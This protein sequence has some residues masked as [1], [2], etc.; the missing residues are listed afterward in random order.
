MNHNE[1]PFFQDIIIGAGI[2]GLSYA[3]FSPE[4]NYMI[5]EKES[6]I[7]GYCRTVK[8][9]GYV[10][11]YSGH[12]FHFRDADIEKLLRKGIR[13]DTIVT[14]YKSTQIRYLDRYIDF[15]F[16]QNIHQ[17][18]K[19]EFIDCL[20]DFYFKDETP[21]STFKEMVYGKLGKSI[22]EKFL[23]PYNEKLYA[24]DLNTLDHR[25]M[26]RFFPD[27]TLKSIIGNF[28]VAK[29]DSYNATFTCSSGGA[30]EYV[31]SLFKQVPDEKVR[32]NESVISIEPAQKIVKTNKGTYRYNRLISSMPFPELLDKCGL[33]YD[34]SIYTWNQ[35][36]VFNLGFDKKGNDIRNHWIYF[37]ESKYAF[38]RVGYYDNILNQNRMSLY[39]E[40]GYPKDV[41]IDVDAIFSQVMQDLKIAGIITGHQLIDHHSVIMNPAYVHV[42][43]QSLEDIPLKMKELEEYNIYSIG[44]YGGWK[45]C[46]I[47]DNIKEARSLVHQ[48]QKTNLS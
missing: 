15:P 39:V 7:G 9:N 19:A 22:S 28:K 44:R 6:E 24:C 32:L 37:P 17:L 43:S 42:R 13:K 34:P 27:V 33:D 2:S 4:K 47:E 8:R 36:L 30:I 48:H 31:N 11:D 20:Y 45:Y 29:N 46:S 40:V 35:V 23:I 25:A 16:Q 14:V 18:A 10:W 5:F 38:Y 3:N 41:Q 1:S 21:W 12:F 26:D